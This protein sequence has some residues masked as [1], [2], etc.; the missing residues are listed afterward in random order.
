MLVLL[1]R[2]G[3]INEDNPVGVLRRDEFV[4]LPGAV[5]AI[6]RLTQAGFD[7]AVCTNQAAIG[8]GWM[9]E[10]TLTEIHH[11]MCAEIERAGGRIGMIYYAKEAPDFP[12]LRRKPAPGMLR[13][14]LEHFGAEAHRTPMVG[15]MQRDLEAARAAGCPRILVRTG[16]GARL[17]AQ[18]IPAALAPVVV[19]DDL[20]AA[21]TLIIAQYGGA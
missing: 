5:A 19:M 18:G 15:D 3:V 6:V 8:K 9:T 16:K 17:E 14:A 4:F 13:E 2:D 21:A 12:S 7:I 1:D 11:D 10:E 20:A